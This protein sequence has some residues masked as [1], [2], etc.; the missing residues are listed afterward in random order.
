VVAYR[1]GEAFESMSKLMVFGNQVCTD[2]KFADE[3][4]PVSVIFFA[5]HHADCTAKNCR[6]RNS[7]SLLSIPNEKK[8]NENETL[9]R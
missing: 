5:K 9:Q 4:L 7:L 3:F 1:N 2:K 8:S 6:E